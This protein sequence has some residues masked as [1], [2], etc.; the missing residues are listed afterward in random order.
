MKNDLKEI[1]FSEEEIQRR[2]KELGAQITLDYRGKT[3]VLIG[4]LKGS[5]V[6]LADLARYIDLECEIRF[7]TASSYGSSAIT[8]GDIKIGTTFDY[9]LANRDVI[10]IDDILDTGET[11]TALKDLI[12]LRCPASLRICAMLDKPARRK[13]PINAYYT[14][15]ECP[16]EFVVGYGLDFAEHYRNLPFIAS[17]KPEVYS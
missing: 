2:V 6:F 11:L 16:D 15:F 14:G 3:P 13:S 8:S 5:F 7:V 1:L 17:L 12:S 10:L 4:V 9:E